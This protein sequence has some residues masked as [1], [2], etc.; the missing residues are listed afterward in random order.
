[1]MTLV[2]Y[3]ALFRTISCCLAAANEAEFLLL[4]TVPALRLEFM[5]QV[6]K[7]P[8]LANFLHLSNH[9]GVWQQVEFAYC[10]CRV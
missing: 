2:V 6:E 5:L 9:Y 10:G 7:T 1:M 8:V 4:F 3:L